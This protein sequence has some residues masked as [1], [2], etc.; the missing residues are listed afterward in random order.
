MCSGRSMSLRRMHAQVEQ[1]DAGRQIVLDQLL[2]RIRKE[3]LAAVPDGTDTRAAMYA[4]T[5]VALVSHRRLARVQ[6]HPHPALGSVGPLVRGQ[7]ALSRHRRVDGMPR[8]S[9]RDEERVALRVD[10]PA[11]E[12]GKRGPQDPAM[13]REQIAVPVARASSAGSSSPRRR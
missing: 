4:Q 12:L 9:E 13:I 3:D 11:A 8:P 10:L 6:T 5:V 2:G 1:A 7:S